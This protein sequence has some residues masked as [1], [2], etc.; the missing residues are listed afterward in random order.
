MVSEISAMTDEPRAAL[1]VVDVQK[2][3]CAGGALAAPGG[4][5][6]IPA[7][8]R[9]VA[10]ASTRGMPVYATR[11]WHPVRTTHFKEYG[12]NWPPHC[13]Q[14]TAG[15]QFHPTLKLPPDAIIVNKGD[16]P[17]RHGYSAFEGHT[18]EGKTLLDDLRDR[19][20]TRVYVAGIATDYCVRQSALD[21]LRAGLEVRVLPDA[22]AGIDVRPGDAQR[23]LDEISAA[24]AELVPTLDAER[25]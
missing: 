25:V 4:V 24:G 16:D 5:E 6:I 12:G 17:E 14:G 18:S 15:A 1:L 7:V 13:V 23:A 3:F 20:I 9:H 19:H 8:N 22:I 11:D 2:D 10:A 21:A